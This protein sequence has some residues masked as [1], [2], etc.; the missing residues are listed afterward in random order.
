LADQLFGLPSSEIAICIHSRVS[1]TSEEPLDPDEAQIVVH[2]VLAEPFNSE[3]IRIMLE[4]QKAIEILFDH[5]VAEIHRNG[6][7]EVQ[8]FFVPKLF[9]DIPN[10]NLQ[11]LLA[12]NFV[13]GPAV[14]AMDGVKIRGNGMAGLTERANNDM[15]VDGSSKFSHKPCR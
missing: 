10:P 14:A 6:A 11:G 8:F 9:G 7:H 3:T 4:I 15:R 2:V 12:A 13:T 1:I 5:D